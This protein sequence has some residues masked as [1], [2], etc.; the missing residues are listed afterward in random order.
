MPVRNPDGFREGGFGPPS[1][2]RTP[3]HLAK[4]QQ[5]AQGCKVCKI[6]LQT[7]G[8]HMESPWPKGVDCAD[9]DLK[10]FPSSFNFNPASKNNWLASRLR[11]TLYTALA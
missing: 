8:V 4:R 7:F 10:S 5:L 11:Y 9:M 6:Q 2:T 1:R 3:P